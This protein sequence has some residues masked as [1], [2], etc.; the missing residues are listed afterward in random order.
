MKASIYLKNMTVPIFIECADISVRHDAI[1]QILAI[2][3]VDGVP[4]IEHL[5]RDSVAAIVKE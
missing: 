4:K 1:G 2:D 3:V 5:S